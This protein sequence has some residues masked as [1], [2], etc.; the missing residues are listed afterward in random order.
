MPDAELVLTL[1]VA[2]CVLCGALYGRW[3]A[4]LV[5]IPVGVVMGLLS[6]PWEVSKVYCGVMWG[7]LALVSLTIGAL[8]RFVHRRAVTARAD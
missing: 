3:W 4:L 5:A 2:G 6:D 1:I 7:G 8:T